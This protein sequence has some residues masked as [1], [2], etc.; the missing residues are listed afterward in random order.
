MHDGL[1]ARLSSVDRVEPPELWDDVRARA[2]GRSTSSAVFEPPSVPVRRRLAA[3]AAALVLFGLAA[4]FAW[5]AFRDVGRGRS[6][7]QGMPGKPFVV[8]VDSEQGQRD[9]PMATFSFDEVRTTVR[10][11]RG[12]GW[13]LGD[14]ISGV[15]LHSLPVEVPVGTTLRV[16]SNAE[17]VLMTTR[18]CCPVAKRVAEVRL[19]EGLGRLPT[20]PGKYFLMTTASWP[21]GRAEYSVLVN[22]VPSP[23]PPPSTATEETVVV[24]DVIGLR[25]DSA[26]HEIEVISGLTVGSV[27]RRHNPEWPQGVVIDQDP[28]PGTT[29]STSASVS[30]VV[31][32]G[33]GGVETLLV[34]DVIALREAD[35]V[36]LLEAAG[37]VVRIAHRPD[38]AVAEGLVSA[39]DPPP[40]TKAA[41]G[42]YVTVIVSTGPQQ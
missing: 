11:V 28:P 8:S 10:P 1:K 7:L 5:S 30:L 2:Q 24:R 38:P 42:T 14:I 36:S 6:G 17:S 35:A 22:V 9:A 33:N 3:A 37:F 20:T 19:E 18:A 31:S 12:E 29:V 16:E 32:A 41:K 23:T 40:G 4:V 13:N 25:Q 27:S 39:T 15:P 26:V 21:E 34:R